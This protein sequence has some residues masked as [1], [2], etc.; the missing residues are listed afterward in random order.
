MAFTISFN[1]PTEG[2]SSFYS[3]SPEF[4]IGMNNSFYSFKKGEMYIHNSP[5]VSVCNYY[6]TQYSAT[7][8]SLINERPLERK[9]FKAIALESDAPWAAVIS[10]D[11]SKQNG[12]IPIAS[13]SQKEGMW[14]S[15]ILHTAS[16]DTAPNFK[17]RSAIGVGVASSITGSM[18]TRIFTFSNPPSNSISIGDR[19]W[20]GTIAGTNV[21]TLLVGGTISAISGNTITTTGSTSPAVGASNIYVVAVK[22]AQVESYGLSGGYGLITLTESTTNQSELFSVEVDYM[23]SFP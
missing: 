19:L 1:V 18:T 16:I 12:T 20:Y 21:S 9:L 2:W 13:Y 17:N 5:D 14:F 23:K 4:M 7:I 10:T 6:E 11:E 15:N 22:N 3:Y 8:T